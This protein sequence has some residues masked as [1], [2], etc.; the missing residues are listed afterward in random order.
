MSFQVPFPKYVCT[1]CYA[2]HIFVYLFRA[3]FK[4]LLIKPNITNVTEDFP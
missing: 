3:N 2:P 1:Y 4:G